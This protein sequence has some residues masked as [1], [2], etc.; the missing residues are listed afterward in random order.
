[1]K[2]SNASTE[3]SGKWTKDKDLKVCS[4]C[5]HFRKCPDRSR[6]Y[7]CTSFRLKLEKIETDE[8]EKETE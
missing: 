7:A 1:M 6:D 5:V 3:N 8:K 2:P 4:Q